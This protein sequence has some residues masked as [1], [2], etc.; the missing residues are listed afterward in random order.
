MMF[1]NVSK[2]IKIWEEI[3][4][5]FIIVSDQLLQKKLSKMFPI[6]TKEVKKLNSY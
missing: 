1:L 3:E 2:I 4:E 5:T 6:I